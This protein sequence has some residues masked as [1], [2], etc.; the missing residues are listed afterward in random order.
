MKQ[1]RDKLQVQ[2]ANLETKLK[3]KQGEVA[4][5]KQVTYVY[6]PAIFSSAD[7]E[8]IC[9]QKKISYWIKNN[10]RHTY[11]RQP[12]E[13]KRQCARSSLNVL[14][15][16]WARSEL[17]WQKEFQLICNAYMKILYNI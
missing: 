6:T 4:A 1:N 2:V 3:A 10:T 13:G 12:F 7:R 11:S 16:I 14:T 9:E 5:C 8:E 15:P 17:F